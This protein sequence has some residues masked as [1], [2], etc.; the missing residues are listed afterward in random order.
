MTKI[1]NEDEVTIANLNM[2]LKDSGLT[3]T[4]QNAERILLYTDHGVG[5]FI[6]MVDR[7]RFA[8]LGT[9]LPLNKAEPVSRKI[10][11]ERKLNREVFLPTFR[12]DADDDLD[13]S[14]VLTYQHGLIA[15][16]FI[17]V[18]NRFA[19]MLDYVVATY[20]HDGIICFH[21]RETERPNGVLLN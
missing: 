17:S 8:R 1:L 2:H 5:F 13:I 3:P 12:L 18:V 9:W 19:S 11:L 10:D 7:K 6:T 14:Y 15:G 21:E 16:Q 4:V 20:N